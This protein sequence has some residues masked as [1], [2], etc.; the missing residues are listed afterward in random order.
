M[1]LSKI[2]SN[3]NEVFEDII[4]NEGFN[5]IFA[6]VKKPKDKKKD[7][8]NLGKTL[9]ISLIEFLLLK[10]LDKSHFLRRHFSIFKDFEFYL[11][12]K[13]L[14]GKY[15]TIKRGVTADTKVSFKEHDESKQDFRKLNKNDWTNSDIPIKKAVKILNTY[16]DLEAISPW[17]YRK[18]VSYFLRDQNDYRDVFQIEKFEHNNHKY[19]KPYLAKLLGFDDKIIGAKYELDD[20]IEN[21]KKYKEGYEKSIPVKSEEYDKLK[22]AIEIKKREVE[23]ISKEIDLFNFYEKE[24]ELNKELLDNVELEISEKNDA[25]YNIGFELDKIK[26]SLSKKID[27][28]IKEISQIFEETQIYLPNELKKSY[29][30]LVQFNKSLF[31]ERKEYLKKRQGELESELEIIDKSLRSLNLRRAKIL[32][33]LRGEETFRKFKSLQREL[34]LTSSNVV[35]MEAELET[36]N[37]VSVIQKEIDS[38]EE[39]KNKLVKK[40]NEE[41]KN[42]NELYSEIRNSFSSIIKEVLNAF[43]N[44][45]IESNKE[46]NPEFKADIFK[47]EKGVEITSAEKGTTY[48]K[49]LCAAF[50][51]AILKVYSKKKFFKFVYHDGILEGLDN[52]KKLSLLDLVKTFCVEYGIQYILTAIDSDLPRDDD[53]RKVNFSEKEIIKN[54]SDEGSNG[55]LFKMDKF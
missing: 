21:R 1:K 42:G 27:F 52:R 41:I 34:I 51:L 3:K 8:H 25:R 16:L 13:L 6:E 54:L 7:S 28:N 23:E 29:E 11:E 37:T 9:L 24:L 18:G 17:E 43:A 19:W 15:L 53:E 2:Y 46:G 5:V 4:F 33:V 30:D 38:L 47:D 44:L 55:R 49:I 39:D 32:E 14:S 31:E 26:S 10:Q 45:Y 35:K 20:Q 12:I 50:D 36:L 48:K 22:G 40:I